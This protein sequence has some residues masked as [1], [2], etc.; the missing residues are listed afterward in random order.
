[1]TMLRDCL[2]HFGLCILRKTQECAL[3]TRYK[4]EDSVQILVRCAAVLPLIPKN[5]VKD[6]GF[7]ALNKNDQDSAAVTNFIQYVNDHDGPRTTNHIEGW[8]SLLKKCCTHS[9]PNIFIS[10]TLLQKEQTAI[11]ARFISCW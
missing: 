5:R 7:N 10:I 3:G 11:E 6:K 8:H 4:D 9:H 1:M 2:F